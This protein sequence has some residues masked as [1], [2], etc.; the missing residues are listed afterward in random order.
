MAAYTNASPL[1][2]NLSY[3]L[4]ILLFWSIQV[5]VRSTTHLL[6][7][8]WRPL[9]G[10]SFCQSTA[11]PSLAYSLAQVINTSSGAGFRGRS[12]S[13]TLH[14]PP[15]RGARPEEGQGGEA[16]DGEGQ[17]GNRRQVGRTRLKMPHPALGQ[18]NHGLSPPKLPAVQSRATRSSTSSRSLP[19]SPRLRYVRITP[20]AFSSVLQTRQPV[21]DTGMFGSAL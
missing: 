14:P 12:T 18:M 13:S 6:G 15:A 16:S 3:S 17:G 5:N 1:A 19:G 2:H 4:L 20:S 11:A 21:P 9:G 7:K 8:T 10:S